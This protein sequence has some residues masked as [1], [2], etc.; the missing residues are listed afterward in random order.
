MMP[1]FEVTRQGNKLWFV[2]PTCSK[3]NTHGGSGGHRISH[4]DCWPKGYILEEVLEDVCS[5]D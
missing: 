4:C 1:T 2:C 5:G 3:K